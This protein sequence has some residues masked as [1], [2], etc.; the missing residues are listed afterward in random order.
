[1][2]W[3][4]TISDLSQGELTEQRS[5]FLAACIPIS[6][7]QQ[8]FDFIQ[9]VRQKHWDAKHHVY[10]FLLKDGTARYS[11]DG[12]PQSTAGLP[13]LEVMKKQGVCDVCMV[14]TRYFGGILLG[15]GGLVRAYSSAAKLALENA[16]QVTMVSAVRCSLECDYA[17]YAKVQKLLSQAGAAIDDS[18]FEETVFLT[19]CLPEDQ[20]EQVQSALTAMSSGAVAFERLGACY[21]K[22]QGEDK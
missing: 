6:T 21:M 13:I 8:A 10:A 14:V 16:R 7:E 15:T 18:I 3:Y 17:L 2:D 9:S 22:K 20:T 1:M 19:F 12:E 11:D 5:R 4:Q